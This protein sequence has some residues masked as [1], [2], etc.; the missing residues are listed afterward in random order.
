MKPPRALGCD[1]NPVHLEKVARHKPPPN[2]P[3]K[4]NKTKDKE[5][6][7]VSQ[8]KEAR[9]LRFVRFPYNDRMFSFQFHRNVCIPLR[10]SFLYPHIVDSRQFF[11]LHTLNRSPLA[12]SHVIR[13][14]SFGRLARRPWFINYVNAKYI[15]VRARIAAAHVSSRYRTVDGTL[16]GSG[17][18]R[19]RQPS[20]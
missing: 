9:T 13:I 18:R 5:T 14:S 16:T 11:C 8:A 15:M 12:F 6:P 7:P 3:P 10:P 17:W 20:K 2:T 4:P 19:A 1:E